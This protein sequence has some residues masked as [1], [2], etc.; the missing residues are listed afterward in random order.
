MHTLRDLG[1]SNRK[2][3][4]AGLDF[5]RFAKMLIPDLNKPRELRPLS[6]SQ[7]SNSFSLKAS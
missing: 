7:H 1:S 6:S 4:I 5:M 2:L 3:R